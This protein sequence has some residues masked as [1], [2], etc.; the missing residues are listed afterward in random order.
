MKKPTKFELT[1][2]LAALG[3][4]ALVGQAQAAVY[5]SNLDIFNP[6]KSIGT[7]GQIQGI[8]TVTDITGGVSVDV[9]LTDPLTE[10]F[11]TTGGHTTFAF[12]L[13]PHA[14]ITDANIGNLTPSASFTV[15]SPAPGSFPD[16]SYGPFLYGITCSACTGGSV[17]TPG[18]LDFTISGIT[19]QNFLNVDGYVFAAD[20]LGLGGGTGAV[21]GDPLVASVPEP[22]T[23]AMMMLGFL[24]VGFMAYRRKSQTS[25]RLA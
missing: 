22:A 16:P 3:L 6:T 12:N 10:S 21:A 4:L 25:F 1:S 13:S 18:P 17:H 7:P 11:V 8:V 19:T 5:T 23:W 2:C 9:K 14:G 20:L 24:G 15:L